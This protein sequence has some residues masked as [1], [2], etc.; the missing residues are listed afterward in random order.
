[1][2]KKAKTRAAFAVIGTVIAID[3]AE[4][5]Q[6]AAVE[7]KVNLILASYPERAA[8]TLIDGK[9]KVETANRPA[10]VDRAKARCP[11]DVVKHLMGN[12]LASELVVGAR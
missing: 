1:M 5:G 3:V 11:I 4:A 10:S 12:R 7:C 6:R 8:R 9:A 2:L